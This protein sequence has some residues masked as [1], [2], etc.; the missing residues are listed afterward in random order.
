MNGVTEFNS[1]KTFQG[2]P[3]F[4]FE[5]KSHSRIRMN[6]QLFFTHFIAM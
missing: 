4:N 3:N 6:A 2:I 1:K 5:L